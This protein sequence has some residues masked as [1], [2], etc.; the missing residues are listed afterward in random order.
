MTGTVMTGTAM[1]G[2]ATDTFLVDGAAVL[3][4]Q[5]PG[6]GRAAPPANYHAL[7]RVADQAA[8]GRACCGRI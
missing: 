6:G 1:T 3:N 4:P 7:G 2:T 8:G 5:G